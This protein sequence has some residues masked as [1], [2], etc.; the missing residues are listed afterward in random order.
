MKKTIAVILCLTMLLAGCGKNTPEAPETTA[1]AISETQPATQVITEPPATTEPPVTEP[2]AP[3][4]AP[5]TVLADH[6]VLIL[7]TMNRGDTVEI[8][9]EFDEAHY[10]VKLESG[11]GSGSGHGSPFFNDMITT[12]LV[13]A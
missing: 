8:A 2:P 11:L 6:T 7:T 5:G 1:A 13:L 4:T 10:V 9:G 3:E 12:L